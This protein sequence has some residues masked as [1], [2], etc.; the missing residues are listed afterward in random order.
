MQVPTTTGWRALEALA[1][2]LRSMFD[3]AAVVLRRPL[4]GAPGITIDA[5]RTAALTRT[6][7]EALF[8]LGRV[9]LDDARAM[10]GS[11]LEGVAPLDSGVIVRA[12]DGTRYLGRVDVFDGLGLHDYVATSIDNVATRNAAVEALGFTSGN[13]ASRSTEWLDLRAIPMH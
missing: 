2:P 1:A 11:V 10:A 7:D 6:A 4:H 3:E 9:S 8:E 13:G 12:S 5:G